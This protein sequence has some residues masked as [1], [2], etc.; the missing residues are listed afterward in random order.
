MIKL[1]VESL[2]K[3][4]VRYVRIIC[5]KTDL[6]NGSVL[7]MVVMLKENIRFKMKWLIILIPIIL[8]CG[9]IEDKQYTKNGVIVDIE[10][11][12]FGGTFSDT[13]SV[14]I[15]DDNS[16]LHL[17]G[18]LRNKDKYIINQTT[19]VKYSIFEYDGIEYN[20]FDSLEII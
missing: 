2:W 3:R 5:I 20:R 17:T 15:Y 18:H 7:I 10:F 16:E 1:K 8:L 13:M 11:Y 6:V 19:K 12:D 9:C 4:F 14:L